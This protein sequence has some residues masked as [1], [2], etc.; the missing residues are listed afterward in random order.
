MTSFQDFAETCQRIENIPGSLEMT[1]VV[2]DLFSSVED[3]ELEIVSR[4]IMGL[5][6]PVWSPLQLG[7]GPSL[8]YTSLSRAS[9][10]PVKGIINLVRETGDVGLAARE[11]LTGAQKSQST[12]AAFG[13][14][15]SVL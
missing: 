14:E 8:L 6:F 15:E 13:E 4:F 5:V 11:A 7:I 2:A 1:Q 3:D 9:G 12:L 10:V